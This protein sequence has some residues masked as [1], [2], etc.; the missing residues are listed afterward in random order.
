MKFLFIDVVCLAFPDAVPPATPMRKG[1]LRSPELH[2]E[3]TLT[4]LGEVLSG[5]ERRPPP[6]PEEEEPLPLSSMVVAT[7]LLLPLLFL[8]WEAAYRDKDRRQSVAVADGPPRSALLSGADS[9]DRSGSPSRAGA[10]C[11]RLTPTREEEGRSVY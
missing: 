7:I 6:L 3:A 5:E 2:E 9:I 8:A 1:L 11:P 10:T 4:A